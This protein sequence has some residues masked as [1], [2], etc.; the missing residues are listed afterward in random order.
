MEIPLSVLCSKYRDWNDFFSKTK[1]SKITIKDGKQ[2]EFYE[3]VQKARYSFEQQRKKKKTPL[4]QDRLRGPRPRQDKDVL[5]WRFHLV[6][7]A[8]ST[9]TAMISSAKPREARSPSRMESKES[10]MNEYRR[11]ATPSSSK[12]KRRRKV[13]KHV[14][15]VSTDNIVP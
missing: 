7:C 6:F 4:C 2:R 10:S 13:L 1:G 14:T 15:K 5:L 12:G 9:G 11:H 8:Q 3:R